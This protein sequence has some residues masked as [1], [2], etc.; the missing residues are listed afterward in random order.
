MCKHLIIAI[1][2]AELFVIGG[3]H[4]AAS[5]HTSA[6]A[7]EDIF[8]CRSSPNHLRPDFRGSEAKKNK[9]NCTQLLSFC[10]Y[11]FA[12]YLKGQSYT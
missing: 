9:A 7:W 1:D 11:H 6:A 5:V 4:T 12:S 3:K 8:D 10:F 2:V